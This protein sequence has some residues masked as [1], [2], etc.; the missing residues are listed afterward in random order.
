L[1]SFWHVAVQRVDVA[2]AIKISCSMCRFRKEVKAA[3]DSSRLGF[4]RT[5]DLSSSVLYMLLADGH[6]TLMLQ[7]SYTAEHPMGKYSTR[8]ATG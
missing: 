8:G 3:G 4:R 6:A 7:L 2:T 1:L 5:S